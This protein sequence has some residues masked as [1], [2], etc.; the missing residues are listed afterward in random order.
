AASRVRIGCLG[1]AGSF[2]A[3]LLRLGVFSN[4]S[5]H[6]VTHGLPLTECSLNNFGSLFGMLFSSAHCFSNSSARKVK[7]C[8]PLIDSSLN[9]FCWFFGKFFCRVFF[10]F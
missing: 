6:N 1:L 4:S 9:N 10:S 2:L 8:L 3:V 5:V 7:R